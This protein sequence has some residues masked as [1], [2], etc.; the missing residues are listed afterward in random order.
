MQIRFPKQ[1]KAEMLCLHRLHKLTIITYKLSLKLKNAQL[2]KSTIVIYQLIISNP[3]SVGGN[4]L[5]LNDN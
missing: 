4:L 2:I 3:T 1:A 5:G